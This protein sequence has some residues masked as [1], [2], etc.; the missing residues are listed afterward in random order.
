MND[1]APIAPYD[2]LDRATFL[3][4]FGA[5]NHRDAVLLRLHA[6]LSRVPQ[7]SAAFEEWLE[8][9]LAWIFSG[10]NIQNRRAD[11][12]EADARSRMLCEAIAELPSLRQTLSTVSEQFFRT[13]NCTRLLTDVGLPSTSGFW[14]E[15]AQRSV[16]R[17]FPFKPVGTDGARFL[18]RMVP[19]EAVAQWLL[20]MSAS[21][22]QRLSQI[23]TL[24]ESVFQETIEE[25]MREA[26][27]I[28]AARIGALGVD[29][30][31]RK[32]TAPLSPG[33]SEAR[34]SPW[35]K[36]SLA[37][38][39]ALERPESSKALKALFAECHAELKQVEQG[40]NETGISV[41]LVFQL[42][43]LRAWMFRLRLIIDALEADEAVR[44]VAWQTL[45]R[46]LIRGAV[47]DKSVSQLLRLNTR[48]L[49]QRL[50]ERAGHSGEKY[51]TRSRS[52]Q[53]AM[54]SAA[55]GGGAVTA[56]MVLTKFLVS[57]S[58]LPP[59][60]DALFL[61]LNYAL[62]FVVMQFAH[63]ALATKQPSMTAATLASSI[64]EART[65]D[66]VDLEPLVDQLA[67]ASRTQL[68]ALGGNLGMVIPVAFALGLL[69]RLV[70]GRD[71]F[72][73]ATAHKVVTMHHPLRSATI[74]FAATT[75]VWLWLASILAGAVENWFVLSEMPG[76]IA[77]NRRLRRV[78]GAER[79][80]RVAQYISNNIS[81]L[82]GNI[83][84]G[85]LLGFMPMAFQ[86]FGIPLEV[87]HVTFIAG[88]LVYAGLQGGPFAVIEPAFL[89]A[90][91][92]VLMVGFTNFSVS[93]AL[94]LIVA[95]R[96]R[97]LGLK[98][99]LALGRA[100]LRRLRVAPKSFFVAPPD[101]A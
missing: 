79:S 34:Q 61:G 98:E 43:L 70:F 38:N 15:V 76:A 35:L 49:A 66:D 5:R 24:S 82:G 86:L 65:S 68:A 67:R 95:L 51:L 83:G 73:E 8:D 101:E 74:L 60:F 2:L 4:R 20:T 57:W 32:R 53:H 45:E 46:D 1:S 25:A 99:Q 52:E 55:A 47:D 10:G 40:L 88:Q 62:G 29:D 33:I 59:L 17:I 94:A 9:V 87:R 81:G 56:V 58:K 19:T 41:D 69:V 30:E 93:F 91:A 13:L 100:V 23:L 97:G 84:F 92:S 89:A 64:S 36:L 14:K 39:D 50:V 78:I 37:V 77:S 18:A 16:A 75:G 28:V 80:A 12:S 6:L 3:T 26:A 31:V 11:E 22:R 63:F 71:F 21:N 27:A 96:A 72:D 42:E 7:A 48:R 44:E 90:V 85:L 54:F